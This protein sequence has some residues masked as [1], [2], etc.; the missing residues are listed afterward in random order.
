MDRI[1]DIFDNYTNDI[2]QRANMELKNEYPRWCKELPSFNFDKE[3]NVQIIPPFAGA[4]IRFCIYYKDKH[5]SVYFDAYDALGIM[6]EPYFEYYDGEE[7]YRY[8]LNESEEMMEDIR[9]FL[10]D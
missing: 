1:K 6:G 7:A 5:V 10:N 9:K 8:L 2:L 3:W 4:I